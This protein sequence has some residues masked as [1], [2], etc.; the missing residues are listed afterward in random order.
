MKEL[1]QILSPLVIFICF[2][3]ITIWYDRGVIATELD[4]E[5]VVYNFSLHS[6][7]Y[8]QTSICSKGTDSIRYPLN[9]ISIVLY[10]K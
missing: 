7:Y 6:F 10:I 8:V 5:Y 3:Y 4:S 2:E 9:S 1:I